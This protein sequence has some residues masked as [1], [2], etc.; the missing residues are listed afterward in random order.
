VANSQYA[1][2]LT[3]QNQQFNQMQTLGKNLG[4]S[5]SGLGT[6]FGGGGYQAPLNPNAAVTY[7]GTTYQPAAGGGW[8]A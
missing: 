8:Q 6:Y 2:A 5:I 4:S 1:N 3:A 7:Q